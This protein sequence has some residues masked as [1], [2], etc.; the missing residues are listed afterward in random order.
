MT[1]DFAAHA[2]G[3]KIEAGFSASVLPELER[4][5]VR[6]SD[7]R[8][9]AEAGELHVTLSLPSHERDLREAVFRLLQDFERSYQFTTSVT[10]TILHPEDQPDGP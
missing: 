4:L 10:P 7:L 3:T 6:V 1:T 5:G 9:M 2:Y 8:D